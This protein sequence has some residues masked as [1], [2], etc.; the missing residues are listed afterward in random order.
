[1][2]FFNEFAGYTIGQIWK[3]HQNPDLSQGP[4]RQG[5]VLC[6]LLFVDVPNEQVP[7]L[8]QPVQWT[9]FVPPL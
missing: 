4:F 6:K 1:M 3:D 8:V 7:C 9:G 5:A 2:G